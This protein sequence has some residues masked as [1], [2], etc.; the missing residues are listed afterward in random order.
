MTTIAW[1]GETLA[2]ERRVTYGTISDA[3]RTKISK[4]DKGLCGAAGNS[5]IAAS[6]QRWF[7]AGEDGDPPEL[8]KD[9]EQAVCFIIRPDGSRTV[10]DAYGHYSVDPGPFAFGSGYEI[11]LGAMRNGASAAQ[12][13]ATACIYDGSSDGDIDELRF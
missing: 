10:Y 8:I 9:G 1:D 4:T 13:V 12:A 11:A 3:S 6:F 2:S 5:S 7:E